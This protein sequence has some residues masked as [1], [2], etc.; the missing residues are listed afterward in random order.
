[1]RV[2]A[3][4]YTTPVITLNPENTINDALITMQKN[5]IKRIVITTNDFPIG[6]VT[7]RDIGRFL[8]EDKTSR[9]LDKIQLNEIMS[10]NL[11]TINE[12]QEDVLAQSAIRMDTFQISS[13]IVVNGE[14]KLVGISTKSDLVRNYANFYRN[15]HKVKDYMS[16]KLITCRKSDSLIF[17]LEMLNKNKV[18]RL[19]V[20]DNDG[21]TVGIIT[22]DT[23]LRN[24]KYFK[25]KMNTRDYLLPTSSAKEMIVGNLIGTELLTVESEDDLS[26]AAKIMTQHRI[27]GIPTIDSR[28]NLEGIISS[29]DIANVYSKIEAHITSRSEIK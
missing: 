25:S 3:R 29:T 11:V 13:I 9:A 18:S 7:E 24:S 14:G 22:Y 1:M 15:T 21:K 8:E 27:S 4:Q 19:V 23:F 5:D 6:I 12:D 2:Q 16:R 20:T 17:A 28:G 26:K 10:V